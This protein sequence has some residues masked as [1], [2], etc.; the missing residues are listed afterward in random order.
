MPILKKIETVELEQI[1]INPSLDVFK[2]V[3]IS[4]PKPAGVEVVKL[5]V[6][7]DE[8]NGHFMELV[9]FEEGFVKALKEKGVSLDMKTGQ[10]N[11]SIIAP[12]TKRFGHLHPQ[13][14]E[15][16][17]VADGSLIMG[18]Y[19]AREKSETNGQKSKL[20]LSPGMGVYVPHGVVH[21]LYNAT[22]EKTVLIYF[23]SMHFSAGEDTQELRF[24][25]EDPL[26]WDF[27]EP[28]IN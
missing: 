5:N 4:E 2:Q 21:S 7:K 26:F 11:A 10:T 13:Q 1:K 12:G 23:A 19:D 25:P 3:Y 18:L 9:R 6:F 14:D 28:E 15:I 16:W 24:I 17:I 8:S 20:V 27:L 22:H